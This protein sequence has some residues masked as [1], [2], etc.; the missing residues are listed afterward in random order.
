MIAILV[1]SRLAYVLVNYSE[2]AD[3]WLR[4]VNFY[5]NGKFRLTGLVMNGGVVACVLVVWAFCRRTGIPT[6][7]MFD[8]YAPTLAFGI[9]LTRK[10]VLIWIGVVYALLGGYLTWV[11]FTKG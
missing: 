7:R 11:G 9:F 1:G 5:K 8:I 4:V 6:L 2:F 3:D 10:G